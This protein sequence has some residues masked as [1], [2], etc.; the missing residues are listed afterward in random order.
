MACVTPDKGKEKQ[1]N[2]AEER[3]VVRP[4][5]GGNE[6]PIEELPV[7]VTAYRDENGY[8]I[9]LRSDDKRISNSE[10]R[11]VDNF[12]VRIVAGDVPKVS[13]AHPVEVSDGQTRHVE[14]GDAHVDEKG[15]LFVTNA[16]DGTKMP[17]AKP[18]DA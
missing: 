18:T 17:A 14:V 10:G 5:I 8:A 7:R 16:A 13:R 6:I 11:L 3:N 2:K 4:V 15:R 12:L 9:V 1:M